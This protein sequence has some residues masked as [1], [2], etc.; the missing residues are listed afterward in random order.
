MEPVS[1]I[2]GFAVGVVLMGLVC[3]TLR[4]RRK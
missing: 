4:I 1:L 3:D 2:V